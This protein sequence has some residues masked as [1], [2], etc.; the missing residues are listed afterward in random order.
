MSKD[1]V[2]VGQAVLS[3]ILDVVPSSLKS[4]AGKKHQAN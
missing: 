3:K 1:K 4:Q 2:F